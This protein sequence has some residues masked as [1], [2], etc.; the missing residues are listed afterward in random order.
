M[1]P[2]TC[3]IIRCR[4]GKIFGPDD[5]RH[6]VLQGM[7]AIINAGRKKEPNKLTEKRNPLQ[8]KARSGAPLAPTA[9][10]P[11]AGGAQECRDD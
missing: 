3:H 10:R 4:G 6:W 8:G 2:D 11:L 7:A 5:I 1:K 9:S